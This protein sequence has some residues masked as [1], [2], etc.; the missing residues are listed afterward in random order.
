MKFIVAI[1]DNHVIGKDG[2]LPWHIPHDLRYF[3]ASTLHDTVIMGRRTWESMPR[4]KDRRS[5]VVTST[6]IQGVEC[7][8]IDEVRGIDGWVIG[9]AQLIESTVRSGDIMYI[10]HVRKHVDG[11][12]KLKLPNMGIL[13]QS[14]SYCYKS[15]EYYFAVYIVF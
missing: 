8:G 9:G 14:D 13:Y 15:L 5:I 6:P 12:T 7:I 11:T 10:T 4:L 2:T 3:K 1:S